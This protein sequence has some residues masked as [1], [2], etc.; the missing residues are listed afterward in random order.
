MR[1]SLKLLL[2]TIFYILSSSFAADSALFLP[3]RD[4]A[5]GLW[6]QTRLGMG[7]SVEDRRSVQKENG[8][9]I[10]LCH[11]LEAARNCEAEGNLDEA[12]RLYAI[13]KERLY[14]VHNGMLQ[15][16]RKAEAAGNLDEATR[17]YKLVAAHPDVDSSHSLEANQIPNKLVVCVGDAILCPKEEGEDMLDVDGKDPLQK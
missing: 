3:K 1:H 5:G 17:L 15:S 10:L 14:K 13:Y 2:A 9:Y 4:F 8:S 11:C 6:E 16:A 12:A 7:L